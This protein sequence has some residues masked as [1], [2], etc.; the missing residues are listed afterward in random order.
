MHD[1]INGVVSPGRQTEE[2][3][4]QHVRDPRQWMPVDG[5]IEGEGP[6]QPFQGNALL[7]IGVVKNIDI[8]KLSLTLEIYPNH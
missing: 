3:T 4:V 6:S 2:L 1:Q 7:Y 8:N 5:F